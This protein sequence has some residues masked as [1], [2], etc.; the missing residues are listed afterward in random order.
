MDALKSSLGGA[1]CSTVQGLANLVNYGLRN[2]PY[3]VEFTPVDS[4]EGEVWAECAL[5]V[6]KAYFPKLQEDPKVLLVVVTVMILSGK[7]KIKKVEVH[8]VG[9]S[10]GSSADKN[11]VPRMQRDGADREAQ[12]GEE[13]GN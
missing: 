2:S 9:N 12:P 5:P 13:L 4:A 10:N 6:F 8:N 11:R 3:R 1:F 7:I